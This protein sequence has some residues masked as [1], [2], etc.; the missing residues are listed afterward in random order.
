MA[1]AG[2]SPTRR[3]NKA[4]RTTAGSSSTQRD[5][6]RARYARLV[7]P[8]A[9]PDWEQRFP[10][11]ELLDAVIDGDPIQM[12]VMAADIRGSTMLMKEAITF[13]S[14]ALVMDKFVT[15]V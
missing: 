3:T 6:D 9:P 5:R 4:S 1:D 12:F 14:F 13:G 10:K 7:K 15:S 8:H 11:E 2:S